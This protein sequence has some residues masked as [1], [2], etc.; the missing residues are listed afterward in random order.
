MLYNEIMAITPQTDIYLLKCP[1]EADNRNQINFA[2]ATAQYNYFN[3]L[4]KLTIDNCT[5]QRHDDVMRLPYHIDDIIQYNYV[6]Y[7]NEAYSNKWFYAFITNMEYSSDHMTFVYIK[8]D[9]FQTWQFDLTYM[10]SFVK[11]EHTNNDAVGANILDEGL[12][13]GEYIVN[14]FSEFYYQSD[15]QDYWIAVQLSDSVSG[16]PFPNNR[17]YNGI[18]QGCWTLLLD[19]S[20]VQNV[21]NFIRRFD[22]DGKAD[23]I[24]S[25][26]ILPKRFA[27]QN[28]LIGQSITDPKGDLVVDIWYL[29]NSTTATTLGTYWW[30]RNTTINGYTPKNNKLFCYPYNYLMISNN[31]GDDTVYHWE[32]FS[33]SQAH[34]TMRGVATQGCQIRITPSNYKNT[35]LD[36]GYAWSSTASTIP[37]LSW[38]SDY[39]L[40]WQAKNGFKSGYN[41]SSSY[42]SDYMSAGKD[43]SAATAAGNL[44]DVVTPENAMTGISKTLSTFGQMF[45]SIMSEVSGGYSASITP[46]ETRGTV[47]G[48]LS[49]SLGKNSFVGY[50]M[51]I[52]AEVARMID[53]YFSMYGYR[54]DRVKVPNVY[55]R[56]YWNYVHTVGANIEGNVPQAD[57]DEIKGLFDRGITIWHDTAHYL[58]YTQNN[59]IV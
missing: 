20:D 8:T 11:R 10:K 39:Y 38:N 50:K 18:P 57:M 56:K 35:N 27:P 3:S 47:T 2:N 26:Y 49:Y 13:T 45:S 33:S 16:M 19:P 31:A 17:T 32:D 59:T 55:G 5:Y 48:D 37:L 1:I 52:K 29:P 22:R 58:D 24:T 4:P 28:T 43:V 14:G 23:A 51:S 12:N 21:N 6:M 7:R 9:V 36:G 44:G 46:D 15:T 40:N 30:D 34:F 41:A 54:T 53:D 42:V 25:M